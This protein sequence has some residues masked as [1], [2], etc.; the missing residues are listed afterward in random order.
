[1]S[2]AKEA[3]GLNKGEFSKRFSA[4]VDNHRVGAKLI[5]KP[6]DLV[7][8]ACRLT[9]RWSKVANDP[10]VEV[11]VK[12]WKAGPR[13]VKMIVLVRTSDGREQPVGK[14]QIVDALY[15]PRK[16]VNHAAPEKKHA[17]AVRGAMRQ[18]VDYQLRNYRSTLK[19]PLL[20]CLSVW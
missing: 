14:G 8:M 19:Y 7:L 6:R 9:E 10:T 20:I 12:N 5:G 2:I 17:M 18:A 11:R 15:P 13:K 3:L 4:I 1:M 16:T